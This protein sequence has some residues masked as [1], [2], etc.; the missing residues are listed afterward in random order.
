MTML[1]TLLAAGCV[2]VCCLGNEYPARSQSTT[3]HWQQQQQIDEIRR[4]LRRQ[5]ID[6][7][8]EEMNNRTDRV[9][10]SFFN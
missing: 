1:K 10:N 7:Q 5:Q 8:W 4:E 2:V 6:R 3:K 9:I